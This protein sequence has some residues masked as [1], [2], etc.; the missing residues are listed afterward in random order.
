MTE[1]GSPA[2]PVLS[3]TAN[4]LRTGKITGNSKNLAVCHFG[5]PAPL[6]VGHITTLPC[7]SSGDT[8]F[9]APSCEPET[10]STWTKHIGLFLC[11]AKTKILICLRHEPPRRLPNSFPPG[12]TLVIRIGA[13]RGE[14]LFRSSGLH[15]GYRATY[16][17]PGDRS[18]AGQHCRTIPTQCQDDSRQLWSAR[19]LQLAILPSLPLRRGSSGS[20]P[21]LLAIRIE[22]PQ[23]PSNV[24][25][26][27][28]AHAGVE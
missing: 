22:L 2:F 21:R 12:S 4:S 25:R 27:D 28:G 15:I 5:S 7:P 9:S 11:Q 13:D 17:L 18:N 8:D 23:C 26:F 19:P 16:W 1:F 20:Q 14:P 3:P 6:I 24:R 10:G